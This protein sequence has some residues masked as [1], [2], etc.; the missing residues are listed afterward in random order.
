MKSEVIENV[1]H[2][3]S[4]A[5]E[6]RCSVVYILLPAWLFCMILTVAMFTFIIEIMLPGSEVIL[7][8]K[9]TI[10]QNKPEI[11]TAQVL[12]MVHAFNPNT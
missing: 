11:I 8:S 1:S 5:S 4:R 10:L 6:D 7:Q 12:S 3:V 9:N 2:G